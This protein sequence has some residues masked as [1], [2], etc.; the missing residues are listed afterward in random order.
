MKAREPVVAGQFYP[1]TK[2]GL[3]KTLAG[4]IRSK[5]KREKALGAVSPHAGYMYSG[6][7]AGQ[8]FSRL[9]PERLYV[10]IG[11]NHTG[12]GKP[13]SVFPK[14]NW[15]T[16]LGNVEVDEELAGCLIDSSALF[17]ADEAAHAYEH[18][19]EVQLPF[20]QYTAKDFKILP[21]C[22]ASA[23]ISDLKKSGRELS[24]ALKKLK[25]DF[26][27]IASSDMTHYEPHEKAKSK[28]MEAISAILKMDED[29]LLEKVLRMDISMCGVGPV[30]IT[31]S[32]AKAMGAKEAEL[33]D[34]R[35][36][37]DASGDYSSVVGYGGV[38][39]R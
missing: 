33:I 2:A 13:F 5:E 20:I 25:K 39:I 24:S 35:T 30:I 10:I 17:R 29:E 26:T 9:T 32:A 27:I 36:S 23:N 14:G 19:I 8:V 38:I 37:G 22:V 1:G 6:A 18:S 4:L 15:N 3:E 21:L 11:P 28:D 34:Y 12:I 31:L 16:P 7:V